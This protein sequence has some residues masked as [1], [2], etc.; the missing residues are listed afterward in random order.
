M[1]EPSRYLPCSTTELRGKARAALLSRRL[2]RSTTPPRRRTIVRRPMCVAGR[3]RNDEAPAVPV[4]DSTRHAGPSCAGRLIHVAGPLRRDEVAAQL[5]HAERVALRLR[6]GLTCVAAAKAAIE[7]RA[8]R[9]HSIDS[10]A[11]ELWR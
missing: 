11:A 10:L 8:A 5:R 4:V 3:A 7:A 6:A 2:E 9:S 1:R